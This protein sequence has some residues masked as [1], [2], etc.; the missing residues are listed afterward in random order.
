MCSEQNTQQYTIVVTQ[1]DHVNV[2]RL[3]AEVPLM[4]DLPLLAF[5]RT[6][7][8][9]SALTAPE[10]VCSFC[11]RGVILEHKEL[12]QLLYAKRSKTRIAIR[13]MG[14]T[15][16]HFAMRTLRVFMYNSPC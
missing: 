11:T 5:E 7:T 9:K 15:H 1:M 6:L 12:Q 14:K 13:V 16:I 2:L 10:L 8:D 3:R 4:P